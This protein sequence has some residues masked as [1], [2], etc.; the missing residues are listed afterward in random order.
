MTIYGYDDDTHIL[1]RYWL[2][3]GFREA[4]A[5][6]VRVFGTP[7][8]PQAE[9]LRVWADQ[10]AVPEP[11]VAEATARIK[12]AEVENERLR[13]ALRFYATNDIHS[14]DFNWQDNGRIA[15]KTLGMGT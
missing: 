10:N 12:A 11:V 1:Q 15:R 6:L 7:S 3:E 9:A 14:V 2:T 8:E 4:A 5:H 13:A